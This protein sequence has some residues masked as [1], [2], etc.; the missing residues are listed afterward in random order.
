MIYGIGNDIV[1]IDRF[2]KILDSSYS[3]R[4]LKR[5]YSQS[6]ADYA[7]SRKRPYEHLAGFFAVKESFLKAIGTGKRKDLK[8]S[9]IEVVHDDAGSP[10]VKLE[11]NSGVLFQKIKGKK[12]HASI[13]HFE[14]YAIATVI[15]EK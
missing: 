2:K 8:F 11:G 1:K 3:K 14:D 13:S 7:F 9:E 6:E 10:H 15:I 4:F 5:V 12:M